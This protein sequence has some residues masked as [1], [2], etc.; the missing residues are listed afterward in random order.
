[1]KVKW[2]AEQGSKITPYRWVLQY[3]EDWASGRCIGQSRTKRAAALRARTAAMRS[4]RRVDVS[5]ID[6][7]SSMGLQFSVDGDGEVSRV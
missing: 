7:W 3:S 2:D 6:G 1:M 5:Y 4:G